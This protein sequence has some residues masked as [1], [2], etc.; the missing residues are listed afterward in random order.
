MK[1]PIQQK[2]NQKNRVKKWKVAARLYGTEHSLKG[3][4]DGNRHKNRIKIE[5]KLGGFMSKT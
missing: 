1:G 3:H 4:K 5:G 2:Y